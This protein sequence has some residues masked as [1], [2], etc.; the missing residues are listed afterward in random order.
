MRISKCKVGFTP[1][2]FEYKLTFKKKQ[3]KQKP[4]IEPA[5]PK[6]KQTQKQSKIKQTNKQKTLKL[7]IIKKNKQS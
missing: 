2:Y 5:K 4:K 6:P 1:I 7:K 3:E